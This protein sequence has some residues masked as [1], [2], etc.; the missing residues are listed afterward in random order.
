MAINPGS[1]QELTQDAANTS[2]NFVIKNAGLKVNGLFQ[3][4]NIKAKFDK[5]DLASSYF[6]GTASIKSIDTGINGRNNSLQKEKYFDSDT[7]PEMKLVSSQLKK[8]SAD[9]YEFIGTLT[10]KDVS[11]QISF[12]FSIEKTSGSIIAKGN[13]A[14]D[15]R[16]Y[17][18][19]GNSWIMG[20]EV[21]IEIVYT[22]KQ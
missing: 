12:P 19:G 10:I 16:D 18:V 21:N 8:G 15:R 14:I 5:N 6:R 3:E 13:F 4:V 20:D 1:S 7:Y 22:G 2:V 17:H 9:Q 11:K